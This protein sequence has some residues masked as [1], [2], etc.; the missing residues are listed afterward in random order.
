[1]TFEST[2]GLLTVTAAKRLG[3]PSEEH[4][5]PSEEIGLPS[6]EIGL[7]SEEI[8]K[9]LQGFL[10]PCMFLSPCVR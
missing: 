7:P 8:A 9:L 5:L 3:L 10:S 6:E 4:A 2:F 1:L